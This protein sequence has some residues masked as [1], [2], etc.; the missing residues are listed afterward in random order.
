MEKETEIVEAIQNW[1]HLSWEQLK[2]VSSV[3]TSD[4]EEI[5]KRLRVLLIVMGWKIEGVEWQ[6]PWLDRIAN[7]SDEELAEALEEGSAWGVLDEVQEFLDGD[8]KARIQLVGADGERLAIDRDNLMGAALELT[9]W[10]DEPQQLM[11]LPVEYVRV[12]KHEYKMPGTALVD[13]AFEQFQEAQKFEERVWM[14]L[15]RVREIVEPSAEGEPSGETEGT[16]EEEPSGNAEGTV[17]T[18]ELTEE[19][20]REIVEIVGEIKKAKAEFLGQMLVRKMWKGWRVVRDEV[21][22]LGMRLPVWKVKSVYDCK[23][24][25]VDSADVL[26]DMMEAPE[27]LFAVVEQ[28]VQGCVTFYA[29]QYK[30]MFS[31]SGGGGDAKAPFVARVDMV[32]TLMKYQGF[33]CQ[34]VVRKM[35]VPDAFSIMNAMS[36]EAEEVE[37]M[38]RESERKR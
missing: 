35:S 25:E 29:G 1:N 20:K 30:S 27:W 11:S 8:G 3:W 32:N 12:G 4:D 22:V 7:L 36:R 23:Y 10:L 17:A 31:K 2:E 18:V 15:K 21:R 9:K 13:V 26:A 33:S 19:D 24:G 5:A 28:Y 38:K 6:L 34:D 37:K 16:E 14:F